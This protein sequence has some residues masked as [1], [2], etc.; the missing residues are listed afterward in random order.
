MPTKAS[1]ARSRTAI[2]SRPTLT[3]SSEGVLIGMWAVEAEEC[4]IYL[5]DEY[6]AARQILLGAIAKLERTDL[7]KPGNPASAPRRGRVYLR[8]GIG[9]A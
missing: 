9:D 1:P 8:R 5:R 3:G 6:P 4:F 7:L 2:S